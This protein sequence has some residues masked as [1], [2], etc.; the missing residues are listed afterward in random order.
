MYI[1]M[2]VCIFIYALFF[3]CS[4]MQTQLDLVGQCQGERVAQPDGPQLSRQEPEQVPARNKKINQKHIRTLQQTSCAT[5]LWLSKFR[6]LCSSFTFSHLS[7]YIHLSLLITLHPHLSNLSI[8]SSLTSQMSISTDI[9]HPSLLSQCMIA[10]NHHY[11]IILF[12]IND[13]RCV[14]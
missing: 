6:D 10:T 7:Y 13:G 14:P 4:Y 9:L 1:Y 3:K 12:D 2:Y 5:Y 8:I 11:N